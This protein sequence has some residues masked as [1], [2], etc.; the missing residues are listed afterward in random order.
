[1]MATKKYFAFQTHAAVRIRHPKGTNRVFV[2]SDVKVSHAI[3]KSVTVKARWAGRG[4][5]TI[6]IE[7]LRPIYKAGLSLV[8]VFCEFF[9]CKRKNDDSFPE[10]TQH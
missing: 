1:M 7:N 5:L 8:A 3:N 4:Y 2:S 9:C 6:P 10:T